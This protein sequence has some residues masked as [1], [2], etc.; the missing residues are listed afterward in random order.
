[1]NQQRSPWLKVW[2]KTKALVLN[3]PDDEEP[4]L[5]EVLS[6]KSGK[7]PQPSPA[8]ET[9]TNTESGSKWAAAA[10]RAKTPANEDESTST[11]SSRSV[12]GW[13]PV[14]AKKRPFY[15]S[16]L[17][18]T[19][20]VLLGLFLLVGLR[21][22]IFGPA[23]QPKAPSLPAEAKF[24]Q[25]QASG[26]AE[27]FAAAYLTWDE[28]SPDQRISQMR[29][30]YSGNVDQSTS[31]QLGWNGKGK[32]SA[33]NAH[34]IRL[35]ALDSEHARVTVLVDVTPY[36]G[37]KA[38]DTQKVALDVTVKANNDGSTVYGVPGIVG[39]PDP[40][41]ADDRNEDVTEDTGLADST[42]GD[43][44]KFFSA[45]ATG[46]DL[47]SITAPGSHITGVDGYLENPSLKT[48]TVHRGDGDTRTATAVV[49]W[50]VAGGS[51][52]EQTYTVTLQKVSS[53]ST[54]R[55]MVSKMEGTL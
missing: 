30:F 17:R 24:P 29:P 6:R 46:K 34:A 45:Y 42:K 43:A 18:W 41:A 36:K 31:G 1:M 19:V 26:T 2:K 7:K 54:D 10:Q 40:I 33:D 14:P 12:H 52:S 15:K 4:S 47:E 3:L 16:L 5:K 25:Q 8:S 51:K 48:W 55:W 22:A 23:N 50:D 53:G 32:Q 44:Q 27:E 38:S 20:I 49:D 11:A 13:S 35:N 9:R 39:I 21:T 37:D 28:K